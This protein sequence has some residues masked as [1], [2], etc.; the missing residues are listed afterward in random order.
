MFHFRLKN[1][2]KNRNN[3]KYLTSKLEIYPSVKLYEFL[4]K[5]KFIIQDRKE[6]I[7]ENHSKSFFKVKKKSLYFIIVLTVTKDHLIK[8]NITGNINKSLVTRDEDKITLFLKE[9]LIL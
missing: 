6:S 4:N 7:Q 5:H 1:I 9:N 3:L 8:I 2:F